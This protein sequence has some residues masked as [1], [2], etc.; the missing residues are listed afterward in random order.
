MR[1]RIIAAAAFIFLGGIARAEL[2]L[3]RL[4]RIF[5]LGAQAGTEVQ[6]EISGRDMG[7]VKSLHFD[8]PGL[9]ATLLKP[10]LFRVTIAPDTPP[11]TYEVRAVGKYGI[12]GV[13][14]FAVDQ[15]LE[16]VREKEPND[17]PDKA[18]KVPVNSAINGHSDGNGD[19]FFR[20]SAKKGQRLVIDCRAFRLNS[21]LRAIL[22][23]ATAD[24]KELLQSKPYYNLTDPLLD[25][26]AP[27]DGDYILR[28]HDMTFLGGLPYRLLISDRPHIE[29]AFP[30]AVV[31]GEKTELTILGRN[32]PAGKP[33]PEWV[34]H[35][36]P[37]DRKTVTVTLPKSPA[38]E[39]RFAFR[40][41]L[42]TP[43]LNARGLQL[44]PE[45][46]KNAVNPVTLLF[47]DAPVTLDKEPNDT[48]ETAQP[49]TLPTVVCGRFDKPGDADWYSFTAKAGDAISVN[50]LCERMDFPGDPF[51]IIT[52]AKGNEVFSVDDHGINF[53]SLAQFN[54]DPLGTFRVPGNGTYR[55]FVQERYR[56]GGPRYQYVLS[57]TKSR[58]DFF[59]V[60][61]HETPSDPTCPLVRQGG[62]AF[63][64]VCLNRRDFNGPVTIEAESLPKGVNCPPVHV[65]PQSQFANIVFTAAPDA[66]EWSGA[67]RLKAWA[68]ID[69]QKVEREVRSAQRRWP[70][71]NIST[72]VAVREICLAVREKAPYALKLPP[73]KLTAT[74]GQAL[75]FPVAVSRLWPDFKGPVQV[76]GL[77]LP[78]GFGFATLNIPA[79]KTE[80]KT[81]L[82]VA[83]NVPPGEYSVVLRGDAQVPFNRDA[84]AAS[85]SN[86]RVADPSTPMIVVV[87]APPKKS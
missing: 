50:L 85:R 5:P 29:N 52:D 19:D 81:K 47:A 20:F 3:I 83:G 66:P 33:A 69:G 53:N 4:D 21:T 49:I 42:P 34:V 10:N 16:E 14:L 45:P 73:E 76:N 72:S 23:L 13:Q 80:M 46:L 70:I 77:N 8:H 15:N 32:L 54:R 62:A 28:L 67:I 87:T 2:P 79:D 64:E 12:S 51:V 65:S 18:Q 75:E 58:P 59:P 84:K 61:F 31:P 1:C 11:G 63:C 35:D 48:P 43:S 27:A 86:V 6:L 22:N 82:T 24:G 74:A 71:A 26:T 17:S 36:R 37:L 78:P 56:N 38:A 9:K 7:E 68:M 25:F 60:A 40:H 55:L 41:H 44:W 30:S 57:L 39:Q